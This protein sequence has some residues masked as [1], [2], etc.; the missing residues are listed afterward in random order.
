V[1]EDDAEKLPTCEKLP[2][3]AESEENGKEPPETVIEDHGSFIV[4]HSRLQDGSLDEGL[5]FFTEELVP[6]EDEDD[7]DVDE[8]IRRAW[9][10]AKKIKTVDVETIKAVKDILETYDKPIFNAAETQKTHVPATSGESGLYFSKSDLSNF[11]AN[12]K[13]GLA[14]KSL[15]WIERASS[16]LWDSTKGALSQPTLMA[17]KQSTL[18][19]YTSPYSHAKV[20]SFA[21]SFLKFLAKT[22]MEPRYSSFDVFL[23]MPKAIR[24]RKSVTERIVVKDDIEHVLGH[25]KRAEENGDISTERSAQYSAFI[26]FGAFTGQRSMATMKK[27]TTGQIREALQSKKPVINVDSSQDKIR[28]RHYVPVHPQVV[29]AL[30]TALEGR[31]NDEHAFAYDSFQMWI[32]RQKIPMSRFDGHFVLGDLRKFAEQHG[33]MIMWDQSNRAYILTHGVSGVEWSH[34]RRPLPDSV[35]EVYMKYWAGVSLTT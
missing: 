23:E 22:K 4:V 16:D 19:K 15:D 35:Y 28:M 12:R 17:L 11:V 26:I 13:A 1:T 24:E 30:K 18:N 3:S 7:A 8:R 21:R 5:E 27:L 10:K 9:R 25:I 29:A 6:D 33:D 31:K 34:Y 14:K 20:L 32:K 2:T